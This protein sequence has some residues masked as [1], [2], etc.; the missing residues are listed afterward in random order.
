MIQE[1]ACYCT[2]CLNNFPPE[3]GVSD[4]LSPRALVTGVIVDHAK[5]CKLEFG[6]YV[7]VHEDDIF[8]NN[9]QPRSIGAIALGPTYSQQATYRF[10]SLNT[11]KVL[12]RRAFTRVPLTKDV[13]LRVEQLAKRQ[14]HPTRLLFEN[15][16]EEAFAD[17]ELSDDD[18]SDHQD[19][20]DEES[21]P[22]PEEPIVIE[23]V[24]ND[25]EE[26]MEE[27]EDEPPEIITR[28]GRIV[29]PPMRLVPSMNGQAYQEQAHVAVI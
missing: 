26:Q 11:G 28:S 21:N 23:D 19:D 3:G 4:T 1:L 14:G 20:E 24:P 17:N 16:Y 7:E 10:M 2:K 15:R 22:N 25:D 29:R 13:Q 12:H 8:Q 5:H 6:E 9:L 18:V 27:G